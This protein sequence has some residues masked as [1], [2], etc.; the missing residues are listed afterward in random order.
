MDLAAL[1]ADWPVDN[2]AVIT[3][4]NGERA[5]AGGANRPF[6]LASITKL[7]TAM[8]ALVAHEEGTLDLDEPVAD[9]GAGATTADLLAHTAGLAPDVPDQL[10]PPNRRRIYSTSTYDVLADEISNR[11][12]M[13]FEAYLTEAV[14]T[15]LGMSSTTLR[16]SAGAG[17]T[18]SAHDV[19]ALMA[20]WRTPTLVHHETLRRVSTAH[21]PDLAGV[22]PGFGR[23]DPNPW[24][25]GP[26]IRGRKAP[27]W[28]GNG[29]A[30]STIGHFGQTGTMT[31]S[32][33][34]A[35]L[36]RCRAHGSG[37]RHVGG[38][39]MAR[40][41]RRRAGRALTQLG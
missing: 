20:A 9:A 7:A 13:S 22:L 10:S 36:H 34:E 5:T 24:G 32:D 6:A 4:N 25:I 33:P 14:L 17:A 16:G 37:F 30:A 18:A 29:N 23:H 26:E 19:L 28:T 3:V 38:A 31:W 1:I 15:P 35:L 8:A 11:S 39:G 2:A 27:H 40:V 12:A 41:L 21:R